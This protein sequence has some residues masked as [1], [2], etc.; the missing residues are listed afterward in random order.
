L[1]RKTNE[2]LT[3]GIIGLGYWGP[4]WLRNILTHPN[5]QLTWIVDT[6]SLTLEKFKNLYGLTQHQ[7]S[8]DIKKSFEKIVP[9]LVLIS[10][11][12]ATHFELGKLA[13]NSGS[14]VIIE[15]P[16][17][18]NTDQ[19][20]ELIKLSTSLKLELFVDHTYI[21]TP[22]AKF[23]FEILEK[24]LLG[25]LQFIISS[26]LNLGL[27]QKDVDVIRDLAVH[28]LALFD[29]FIPN[30][31]NSVSAEVVTHLPSIIPSTGSINLSY[32]K[33]LLAQVGVSWNSPVKVRTMI[34]SGSEKSILWDDT[35]QSEKIK[36]YEASANIDLADPNRHISYS[37]GDTFIPKLDNSEAIFL[38]LSHLNNV[39]LGSEKS[40]NGVEHI[41]RVSSILKALETSAKTNGNRVLI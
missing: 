28:D 20:L 7:V 31:L 21:F 10:T 18:L 33:N 34:I 9:D 29:Y 41:T 17:G 26:R 35:N 36:V 13:L 3:I 37:L 16:V 2:K 22:Q 25:D 27:I 24:G 30:K 15:K 5:F 4:N 1:I 23:I 11:P 12:P 32:E 6:N 19:S 8:V 40:L 14:N 38:Q 39:L